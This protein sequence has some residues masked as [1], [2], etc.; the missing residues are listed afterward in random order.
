LVVVLGQ[1]DARVSKAF[2]IQL[3][4]CCG[5]DASFQALDIGLP[6][7]CVL[8]QATQADCLE[9]RATTLAA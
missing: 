2:G 1:H 8:E 5:I 7:G 6:S 9:G 4:W 3:L